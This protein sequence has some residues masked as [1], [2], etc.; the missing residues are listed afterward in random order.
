MKGDKEVYKK[1]KGFDK[2]PQNINRTGA[3]RKTYAYHINQIKSK[4]YA[5]PTKNEYMQMVGLLL[6]M[7]EEDLKN[8]AA[9]KENP[10]WIRLLIIDLNNKNIRS[11]LMSDYRDWLFGKA[12]QTTEN[13][14]EIT[15]KV[16]IPLIEF[17][18]K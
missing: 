17:I 14:S 13:Q 5:A 8:F 18:K 15:N 16:N 12:L 4:G 7:N 10:Y 3:N 9:D 11:K 2:N 1:A 6:V